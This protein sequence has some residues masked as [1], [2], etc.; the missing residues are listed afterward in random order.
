MEI[1]LVYTNTIEP[2]TAALHTLAILPVQD[3]T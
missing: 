1:K 3:R 2:A